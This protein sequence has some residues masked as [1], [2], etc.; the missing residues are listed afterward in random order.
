[1]FTTAG[2]GHVGEA[3]KPSGPSWPLPTAASANTDA[4]MHDGSRPPAT[5]QN[6]PSQKCEPEDKMNVGMFCHLHNN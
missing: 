6:P 1:M 5:D 3:G 2:P 4:E